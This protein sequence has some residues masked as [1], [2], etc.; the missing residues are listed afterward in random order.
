V[1]KMKDIMTSLE[2]VVEVVVARGIWG[3]TSITKKELSSIGEEGYVLT[4]VPEDLTLKEV[5]CVMLMT[6]HDF[7]L[8]YVCTSDKTYYSQL[9]AYDNVDKQEV[10]FWVGEALS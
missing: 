2:E 1:G 4:F 9:H 5:H 7:I 8:T 6:A 10:A 3:S